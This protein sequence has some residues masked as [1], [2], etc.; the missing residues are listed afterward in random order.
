MNRALT[1]AAITEVA[2]GLALLVVPSLVVRLLFGEEATGVAVPIARVT[3]SALLGLGVACWPS[4]N[5][6]RAVQG[7]LTYDLLAALYLIYVAVNGP[8]GIL[9]WPVVVIHAGLSILLIR[10]WQKERRGLGANT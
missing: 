9:L 3:G 2:T 10:T 6:L 4:R 1:I 7:M 5:S 8:A